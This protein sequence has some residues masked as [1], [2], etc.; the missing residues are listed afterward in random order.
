MQMRLIIFFAILLGYAAF[1][2]ARRI[3]GYTRNE[4]TVWMNSWTT[5]DWAAFCSIDST[6]TQGQW[7]D[8]FLHDPAGTWSTDAWIDWWVDDRN[9]Q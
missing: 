7:R 1:T 2:A 4:W 6:W 3:H 8:F 5:N 9:W